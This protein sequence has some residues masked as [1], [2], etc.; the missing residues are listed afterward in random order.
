MFNQ[1]DCFIQCSLVRATLKFV[2]DIGSCFTYSS[3]FSQHL[4]TQMEQTTLQFY[5]V[6][7]EIMSKIFAV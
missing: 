3:L 1:I 6:V 5:V 7:Q 2:Y 4:P